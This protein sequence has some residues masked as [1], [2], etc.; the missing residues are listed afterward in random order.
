MTIDRLVE[1]IIAKKNPCIVGLDPVWERLPRCYQSMPA[2]E[3]LLQWG[4]DVI[5][6]VADLVPAIKP[7]MAFFEVFGPEGLAVHRQLTGHA[8][9]RGLLVIDDSKRSDIGSTAK[10]YAYAHLAGDG[11]INADF[12]TINPFLGLGS[13]QPFLDTALRE[14]KGLFV[15]VK[16]SNP[17]SGLISEAVTCNGETVQNALAVWANTIGETMTGQH[18]YSPLGA[19]VGAT[20]PAEAATL[21]KRMPRS[22]F[23][24]PGFGAQGGTAA[25]VLPCFDAHG[26]GALVSSSRGI[27]YRHEQL[28]GFAH[29]REAYRQ[30]VRRR[31]QRMRED[32]YSVLQKHCAQLAY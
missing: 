14:G 10:A 28:P 25:D 1:S 7:Q 6:A 22:F 24:V 16:T 5:D 26:L 11:P 17:G 2:A 15:L 27:L 8:H 18:G 32:V 4:R 19:V 21:R 23:L 13:M 12:L 3:G 29:T 31:V 30:A 9:A 20:Y